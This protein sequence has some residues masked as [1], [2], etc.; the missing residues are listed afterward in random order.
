MLGV[1]AVV[2]VVAAFVLRPRAA[3]ELPEARAVAKEAKEAPAPKATA[4]S[5]PDSSAAE[6]SAS[7]KPVDELRSVSASVLWNHFLSDEQPL[8]RLAVLLDNV[9]EG[10]LPR[11]ALGLTL[12]ERFSA[13]LVEGR[14]RLSEKSAHRYDTFAQAVTSIDV[15]AAAKVYRALHPVLEAAWRG[16]G[17]PDASLDARAAE[18]LGRLVD[19]PVPPG[20][21][22]LVEAGR[23][24]ILAD[25]ELES[26]GAVEKQLIR[27][28]PQNARRVQAKARELMAALRLEAAAR[29]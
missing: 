15:R 5:A 14:L 10:V 26:L 25:P 9:A 2:G 4:A 28:G 11:K 7:V 27:M 6:A 1:M 23:L 13:D 24:Y 29:R 22:E 20:P 16:L 19:A 17:Y 8:K 12:E 21:I 18:A 3:P